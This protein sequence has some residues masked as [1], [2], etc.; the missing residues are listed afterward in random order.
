MEQII[1]TGK[2]T[3]STGEDEP[4]SIESEDKPPSLSPFI[5]K[6][7]P[8]I[9]QKNWDDYRWQIKN[10]ITTYEQLS[11][12]I[13][14]TEEE[15]GVVVNLPL[16]ITPYYLELISK[17][18]SPLRK[19]VV[20]TFL[21]N[22]LS[23]EESADPLDEDRHSPC[24]NIIH[25][26]PDRVLFLV[27]NFCSTMCR[28]C[29]RS[30]RVG[31]CTPLG[32]AQWDIGLEYIRSNKAIRDVIISGGDPLTMPDA[33]IEY[34]LKNLRAIE[35]VEIIRIGTKVPAVLPQRITPRL[36]GML[37]KYHPL[38]LSLHFTHP[39]EIT[40]ETKKA[41]KLLA[42][43]GIVLG[44][45][46]VLLKNVNDNVNI[47]KRLFQKLVQNRIRPLYLYQCDRIPGS[48]YFI[49]QVQKGIEIIDN[50][51][52]H[53]SSYCIPTFVVDSPGGKIAV[54]PNNVQSISNDTIMLKNYK[55]NLYMFQNKLA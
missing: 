25:K 22:V 39:D 55:G 13:E 4:P 9:T 50:L 18:N 49:V 14:L 54:N 21:E 26:Y 36:V 42:D 47:M 15:K 53:T 31:K 6:H 30:R 3:L 28:F 5:R 35:H 23:T 2:E 34:L 12:F 11:K 32:K 16:R 17:E 27:S 24:P 7:F 38:F 37:K 41:C 43:A 40:E 45:Q 1:S 29:T 44:S 46:T 52:G 48:K 51:R 20:P 19:T 33:S 10:S 8:N